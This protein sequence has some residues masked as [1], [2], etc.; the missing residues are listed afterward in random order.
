MLGAVGNDIYKDKIINSL[1]EAKV[2]PML[3][4]LQE[5]TYDNDVPPKIVE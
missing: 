2:E 5:K 4:I 1:K 3:E